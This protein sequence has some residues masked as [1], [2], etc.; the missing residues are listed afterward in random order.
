MKMKLIAVKQVPR[1]CHDF[2][3]E[4]N[5]IAMNLSLR[6]P[7]IGVKQP[8]TTCPISM[9]AAASDEDKPITFLKNMSRYVNHIEAQQSFKKW[10]IE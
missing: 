7:I 6:I 3:W 9:S 8:S 4:Q 5:G 1:R 10:P 2:R